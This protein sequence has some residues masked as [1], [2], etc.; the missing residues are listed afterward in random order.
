[1]VNRPEDAIEG[2]TDPRLTDLIK[3]KL[4]IAASGVDSPAE[5]GPKLFITL[6]T[7]PSLA[8]VAVALRLAVCLNGVEIASTQ[9]SHRCLD[10]QL[11]FASLGARD[12]VFRNGRWVHP[13][14][15]ALT[16]KISGDARLALR[17]VDRAKYWAGEFEVPFSTVR[18]A[19]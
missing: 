5:S 6:P 11:I 15:P 3:E 16:L 19:K 4:G 1:M 14:D 9:Y 2:V 12:Q 7:D 13:A 10:G 17:E 8:G 18:H